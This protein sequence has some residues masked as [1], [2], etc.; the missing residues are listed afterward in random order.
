M[1][2]FD[3]SEQAM[4]HIHKGA[5]AENGELPGSVVTPRQILLPDPNQLLENDAGPTN[6]PDYHPPFQRR[7]HGQPAYDSH[8][9]NLNLILY[10]ER[11]AMSLPDFATRALLWFEIKIV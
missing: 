11:F 1:M 2:T 8:Y 9:N 5:P 4:F 6:S 3:G 10:F 7:G